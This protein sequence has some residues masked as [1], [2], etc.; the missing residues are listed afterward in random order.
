MSGDYEVGYGRPPKETQF[1]KGQSGNPKGRPK[2][3]RNF[4]TY[5]QQV[6]NKP[7][8]LKDGG[9][10]PAQEATLLRMCE[11]ALKGHPK[12]LPAFVNL[13]QSNDDEE[14]AGETD[15]SLAL[16]DQEIVDAF[17][18]RHQQAAG[19]PAKSGNQNDGETDEEEGSDDG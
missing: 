19:Q 15:E 8:K 5:V 10:V 2:G 11:M 13:A 1:K 14:H 16:S 17:V 3:S 9:Y 12:M 4:K 6:L 7:V 18:K